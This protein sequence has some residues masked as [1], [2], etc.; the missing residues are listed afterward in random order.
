MRLD[1]LGLEV[2][3]QRIEADHAVSACRITGEDQWCRLCGCQGISR[4]TVVRRLT[5][6]P[7]G[8][9]PTIL[10]VSVRRYLCQACAHVWR[11]DMSQAADPRAKISRS[12]VRWALMGMVVHYVTVTRIAQALDV[13]RK[14]HQH[15]CPDQGRAL[16]DQR[17]DSVRRRACHRRG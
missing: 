3:G 10:H 7:Y 16:T 8:W 9:H 5:H 15:R 13:S 2:T 14:S 1:G 17:P 11:Q 4:D 12:A 6:E